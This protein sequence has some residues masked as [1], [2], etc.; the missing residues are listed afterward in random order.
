MKRRSSGALTAPLAFAGPRIQTVLPRL[1]EPL[2]AWTNSPE[3][4][5]ALMR[6]LDAD[7]A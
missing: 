3:V 4:W 2:R 7:Y 1:P 5:D 6:E